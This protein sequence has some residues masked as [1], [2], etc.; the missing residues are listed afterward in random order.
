MKKISILF[1]MVY[2]CILSFAEVNDS[3]G[4]LTKEEKGKLEARVE[5]VSKSQEL[6]F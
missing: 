5:E 6:I 2:M 4:V 1:L 3:I